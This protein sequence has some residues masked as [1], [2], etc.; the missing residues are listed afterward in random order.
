M[1]LCMRIGFLTLQSPSSLQ[2]YFGNIFTSAILNRQG[3][4][5]VY[6]AC[7][8]CWRFWVRP[9]P[10]RAMSILFGTVLCTI[11]PAYQAVDPS[12]TLI[13]R[14]VIITSIIGFTLVFWC[15]GFVSG[16]TFWA[17]PSATSG[18]FQ[19]TFERVW[20]N[21]LVWPWPI[22]KSPGLVTSL[23]AFLP[24]SLCSWR[25]QTAS[26]KIRSIFYIAIG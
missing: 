2:V 5:I 9:W 13:C 26:C 14:T 15:A 21:K 1:Q 4:C 3:K 11:F 7:V 17:R 12:E 20:R 6:D 10:V 19:I 16:Y 23:R 18:R 22:V 24:T 8:F 25:T